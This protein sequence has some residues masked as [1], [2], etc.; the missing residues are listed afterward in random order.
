[1]YLGRALRYPLSGLAAF[2][3]HHNTTW[4]LEDACQPLPLGGSPALQS[5]GQNQHWPTSGPGGYITLAACRVP[6][7]S[8][9]GTK[10]AMAHKWARW[11]HNPYRLEVLQRRGQNQQWPTNRPGGYTTPVP[12]GVPD[13][14]EWGTKSAVAHT[15]AD[16]LHACMFSKIGD[17]FFAVRFCNFCFAVNACKQNCHAV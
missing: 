4:V 1:M 2:V 3:A 8:E 11:L 15:W 12:C 7:P 17:F 9:Y 5:G 16:W 14:S 13:A 6:N 10:S